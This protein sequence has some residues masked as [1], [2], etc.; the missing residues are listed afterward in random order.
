[1]IHKVNCD[2]NI[3]Y[4]QSRKRIPNIPLVVFFVLGVKLV[5]EQLYCQ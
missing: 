2:T 1:M 3:Y 4:G 5:Y